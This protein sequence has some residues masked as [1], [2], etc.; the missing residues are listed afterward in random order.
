MASV[1]AWP[2]IDIAA[3]LVFG[4]TAFAQS[5]TEQDKAAA[6]AE[7]AVLPSHMSEG[8]RASIDKVIIIAG[9]VPA[10][11]DVTG[12]YEKPTP[13]LVGG[14]DKGWE[15]GT[16]RKDIGGVPVTFPIPVLQ[17][18][19]AIFGG[20]SGMTQREIQEFRDAL[21]EDLANAADHPL[22]ADALAQGVYFALQKLP[23]LEKRVFAA[24]TPVPEDTDAVLYV[25]VNRLTIVVDGSDAVLTTSAVATLRR[26]ADGWDL[27]TTQTVYQDRDTLENWTENDNALWRAYANYARH[28]LSREISAEVFD[29]VELNHELRPKETDTID[30][31]KRNDWQGITR[32]TTP[33]L[34]WELTLLGGNTYGA[35]A[36]SIDESDIYYDVEIYD[37]RSLV[38]TESQV[39]DPSHTLLYEL[40]PCKTFRWSVRPSYR[41]G[42]DVKYG[43]WMRARPETNSTAKNGNGNI[44]RQASLAPAYTQDF[45]ELEVKCGRR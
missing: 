27:F 26:L 10:R 15:K 18:A 32:S 40:E 3:V 4:A 24:T 45:A 9:A 6:E 17:A 30:R 44:G 20:I 42:N 34:A 36:D 5:D 7:N 19:G 25:N 16:I 2:A 41:V 37:D 28:Y 14:M 1:L 33:T 8:L 38:Y 13:G 12:S 29:R 11:Q 43:E 31:V 35:W 23:N 39:P 21:T 22:S